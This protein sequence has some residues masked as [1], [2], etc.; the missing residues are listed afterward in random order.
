MS[1]GADFSS[2]EMSWVVFFVFFAR[3]PP[4][5]AEEQRPSLGSDCPLQARVSESSLWHR[6]GHGRKNIKRINSEEIELFARKRTNLIASLLAQDV[7]ISVGG[8]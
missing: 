1:A 3:Q 6:R 4:M 7:T 8:Y 2:A 5:K